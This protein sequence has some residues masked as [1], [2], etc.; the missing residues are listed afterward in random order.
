[1]SSQDSTV[2]L[3]LAWEGWQLSTASGEHSRVSLPAEASRGR[4]LI[5]GLPGGACRSIGMVLPN[6]DHSIMAAMVRAQLERLG[7]RADHEL[8]PRHCWHLVAQSAQRALVS[9]DIL[10]DPFPEELLNLSASQYCS[11]L[12]LRQMPS[13]R[14][15]LMVE[16]GQLLAAVGLHG[17]LYHASLLGAV[18]GAEAQ[19][20]GR[21]LRWMS[22]AL[23]EEAPELSP[24]AILWVGES[25]TADFP[26]GLAAAAELPLEQCAEL[27]PRDLDVDSPHWQR[28]LPEGVV[29]AQQR[30]SRRSRTRRIASLILTLGLAAVAIA[31]LSLTAMEREALELQKRSEATD[32]EAQQVRKTAETWKQLLPALEAKQYPMQMLAEITAL[33]PPSGIVIR[34]YQTRQ[35]Q[36]EVQGDARDAQ[37]AVQFMEDLQKH[38]Q[39]GR[40]QWSKPSP[41]VREGVAQFRTQGKPQ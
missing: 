13:R 4:V 36:V 41:T 37:T 34:R 29:A 26:Q 6:A 2:L 32:A 17:Q 12:R 14:L 35:D 20:W 24:E 39:L 33:M 21:E 40:L 22:L 5:V 11:A 16:Q 10:A 18:D 15:V 9:V 8:G 38:P 7:L 23:A 28:L 1:M 30:A 31:V 19:E 25:P 3:P 27:G